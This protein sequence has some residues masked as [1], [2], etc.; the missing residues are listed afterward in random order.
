MP[1][2]A[3]A[4]YVLEHHC[5]A[6]VIRIKTSIVRPITVAQKQACRALGTAC[7]FDGKYDSYSFM[8][9]ELPTSTW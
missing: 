3:I 5:N 6:T 1:L 8:K 9:V 4:R 7:L 2:N